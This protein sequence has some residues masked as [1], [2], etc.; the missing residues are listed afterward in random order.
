MNKVLISIYNKNRRW[1]N[2]QQSLPEGNIFRYFP[3]NMQ[4]KIFLTPRR[5]AQ[6]LKSK[7]VQCYTLARHHSISVLGVSDC[8][9]I[10]TVPN[11]TSITLNQAIMTVKTQ[12]DLR[13]PLFL[14]VDTQP[15]GF[16]IVTCDNSVKEEAEAFLSHLA[17][18]LE[19]I[20]GMVIWET[21]T[22]D[23][24]E[25]MLSFK[26]CNTKKCAVEITDNISPS[27]NSSIVF[28]NSANYLNGLLSRFGLEQHLDNE[29]NQDV[30]FDLSQQVTLHIGAN[31]GGIL[32]DAGEDSG[33]VRTDC[34]AETLGT[35]KA[36]LEPPINYLL[37]PAV[38][39]K[40]TLAPSGSLS[41]SQ[42]S[43]QP[44]N[45]PLSQSD[46]QAEPQSNPLQQ[47]QSPA[48]LCST[49]ST[50]ST[51]SVPTEEGPGSS[52]ATDSAVS[53]PAPAAANDRLSGSS[54]G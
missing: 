5:S 39:S 34:S 16:V 14:G 19:Q 7:V 36:Y 43:N 27:E 50:S 15:D 18:Y 53:N 1:M 23:Y 38:T 24:K 33:T 22:H 12:Q 48:A 17:I 2:I 35:T 3:Y 25:S 52:S 41:A 13:S 31:Y 49:T 29:D 11:G 30:S 26:Y 8:D 28:D 4:H 10:I 42:A 54:D 37:A 47:P 46:L 44:T 6:L 9:Q 20:F 40:Q 51:S 21:F 32:G 45:Q